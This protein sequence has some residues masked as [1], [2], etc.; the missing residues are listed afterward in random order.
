V[1][2]GERARRPARAFGERAALQGDEGSMLVL[3]PV[4]VLIVLLLGAIAADLSHVHGAKR[5]LMDV[6]RSAANDAATAGIDRAGLRSGADLGAGQLPFDATRAC[7]AARRGI[8]LR[9]FAENLR[10][11]SC[12]T[13][14]VSSD[15]GRSVTISLGMDVD[16]L[17]ARSLPG[18]QRVY[19]S[20]QASA[21]IEIP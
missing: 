20:A 6:A 12:D 3:M 17:F 5:E 8:E 15:G 10:D 18:N 13:D 4:A 16:Y 7:A 21:F 14:L 9:R 2:T 1:L 19:V 11:F